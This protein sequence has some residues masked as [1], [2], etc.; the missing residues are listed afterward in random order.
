LPVELSYQVVAQRQLGHRADAN[1]D[2]RENDDL[3]D[4]QP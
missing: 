1:A 2:D 3:P 4:Q